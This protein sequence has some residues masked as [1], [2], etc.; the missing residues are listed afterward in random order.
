MLVLHDLLIRHTLD[1]MHCE[2]N[3]IEHLMNI[4]FGEE[5]TVTVRKDMEGVN[6]CSNLW[7]IPN[8]NGDLDLPLAPYVM[9][10]EDRF[11][12]VGII[13]NLKVPSSYLSS[14]KKRI[15]HDI[16]KLKGLKAH[17]YHILMQHVLPL[18]VRTILPKG[19]RLARIRLSRVFQRICAKTL[20]PS[21]PL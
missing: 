3:L 6:I 16:Q 13:Q 11:T 21:Q 8:G 19:P 20:D 18:C 5:V 12:F 1:V 9:S 10:L 7:P 4:M 15:H 17:D 2:K 14:L